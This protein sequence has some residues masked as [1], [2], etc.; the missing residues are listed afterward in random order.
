MALSLYSDAVGCLLKFKK[1]DQ[2]GFDELRA[3]GAT[4]RVVKLGSTKRNVLFNLHNAHPIFASLGLYW[5]NVVRALPIHPNVHL[6][7]FDL[8]K[9]LHARS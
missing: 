9:T 5:N 2:V 1:R 3:H 8:A 6:I 7:G 4:D